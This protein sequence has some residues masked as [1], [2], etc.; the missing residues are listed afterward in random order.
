MDLRNKN[1]FIDQS[2]PGSLFYS[3]GFTSLEVFYTLEIKP[4]GLKIKNSRC[5]FLEL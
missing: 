3:Y 4:C 5:L 2:N 1:R